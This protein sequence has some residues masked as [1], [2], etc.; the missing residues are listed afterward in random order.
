MPVIINNNGVFA[1]GLQRD[2][3]VMGASI[4][5]VFYQFFGGTGGA[6]YHL[7]RRDAVNGGFR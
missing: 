6:F 4:N 5:G 7:A 2:L 3:D 1:P